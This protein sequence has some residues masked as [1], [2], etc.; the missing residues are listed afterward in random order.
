MKAY[1][2]LLASTLDV[3]GLLEAINDK[4]LSAPGVLSPGKI[5][6]THPRAKDILLLATKLRL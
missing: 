5:L 3:I 4:D 1:T 6:S 2:T